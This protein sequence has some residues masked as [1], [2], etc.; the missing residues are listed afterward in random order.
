MDRTYR[1]SLTPLVEEAIYSVAESVADDL[2]LT[3]EEFISRLAADPPRAA[4]T[5]Y[6]TLSIFYAATAF[7]LWPDVAFIPAEVFST[8]LRRIAA[9]S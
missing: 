9:D 2:D 7:T 1:E 8:A 3:P 6:V 5:P 4:R